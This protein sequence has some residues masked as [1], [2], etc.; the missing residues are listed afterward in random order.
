MALEMGGLMEGVHGLR[1]EAL[2]QVDQAL[3][4]LRLRIAGRGV[5]GVDG[6]DLSGPELREALAAG[7]GKS[8]PCAVPVG[9]PQQHDAYL[10]RSG[11]RLQL[12]LPLRD[13]ELALVPAYWQL[14]H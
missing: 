13:Y 5:D 6:G 1:E 2:H 14:S 8:L 3:H 9:K 11:E 4:E 10:G 12:H 7:G